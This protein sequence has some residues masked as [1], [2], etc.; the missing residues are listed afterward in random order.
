MI[1]TIIG[2]VGVICFSSSIGILIYAL[3]KSKDPYNKCNCNCNCC[4]CD[5]CNCKKKITLEDIRKAH[6]EIHG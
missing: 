2:I 6:E 5:N 1:E 3:C 4:K